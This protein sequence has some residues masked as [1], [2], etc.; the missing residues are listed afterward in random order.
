MEERIGQTIYFEKL[1]PQNTRR[2]LEIAGNRARELDTH[3]WVVTTS[4]GDT[5][6]LA[7]EMFPDLCTIVATHPVGFKGPNTHRLKPEHIAEKVLELVS[8]DSR[9]VSGKIIE[10][11]ALPIPQL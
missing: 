1:G 3:A 9:I 8:L 5:G 11:H 2:T 4:Y 6:A 10:I 7:V